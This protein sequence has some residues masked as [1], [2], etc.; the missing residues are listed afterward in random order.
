VQVKR[1]NSQNPTRIQVISL[2]RYVQP[3][4][5]CSASSSGMFALI[6][7][8]P[9]DRRA[10]KSRSM[11]QKSKSGFEQVCSTVPEVFKTGV[12]TS[13]VI[14][15]AILSIHAQRRSN[16]SQSNALFLK[17]SIWFLEMSESEFVCHSCLSVC[18]SVTSTNFSLLRWPQPQSCCAAPDLLQRG[19]LSA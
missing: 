6:L 5:N 8:F 19:R 1:K 14:E 11:K 12:P 16:S 3:F 13:E 10:N 15:L 2:N 17:A 9:R 4:Q 18:L 7:S